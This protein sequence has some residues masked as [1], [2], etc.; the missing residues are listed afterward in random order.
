MPPQNAT[1]LT[2]EWRY[3]A[4]LNFAVE[5]A[6]LKPRVPRGTELDDWQGQ[7]FA[8]LVAFHFVNTRVCGLALPFHRTFEEVNLR[9]YVRRKVGDEWRRGVVFIKE[10]VPRLAIAL[11]ARLVYGE[12]YTAARMTHSFN[13]APTGDPESVSYT[14]WMQGRKNTIRLSALQAPS[15]VAP[16]SEEEFITEH[17]WGYTPRADGRTT[18]Y[19]VHHPRWRVASAGM[20]TLEGN[21]DDTYGSDWHTVLRTPP[22]SAFLAEGSVI[23]VDRGVCL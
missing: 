13:H 8:S 10:I 2:A 15:P 23:E 14:W 6:F 11:T 5:S 22:V 19:Q 9:F 1:F 20:A 16:G 18:E 4:M 21:M 7:T 12:N 3:L 17:Y